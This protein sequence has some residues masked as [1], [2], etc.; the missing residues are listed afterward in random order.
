MHI[1][2][3]DDIELTKNANQIKETLLDALERDKL[4]TKSAAEISETYALVVVKPGWLG[5]FFRKIAGEEKDK[6]YI[7]VVKLV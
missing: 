7:K 5:N 1:Y 6:L 3:F 4:L 2:S